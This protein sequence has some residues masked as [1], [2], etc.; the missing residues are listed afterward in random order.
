MKVSKIR[1]AIV[2]IV[3]ASTFALGCELIVDFDRTKIPVETIEAGGAL[4]A[5]SLDDANGGGTDSG[6]DSGVDAAETST[7]DAGDGGDAQP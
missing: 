1:K 2:L 5:S 3:A 7:E 6:T 4:D